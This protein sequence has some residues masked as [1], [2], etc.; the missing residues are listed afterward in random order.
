MLCLLLATAVQASV[1]INEET[2]PDEAFRSVIANM[3][4]GKDGILTDEEIAGI[5]ELNALWDSPNEVYSLK[6]IE[7]F[8]NLKTF[9][10]AYRH[11]RELD[12]SANKKLEY[13]RMDLLPLEKINL[14]GLTSLK[15]FICQRAVLPELDVSDC[16]ELEYL[17]C[18]ECSLKSFDL[19]NNIKLKKL[20]LL[21]TYLPTLD[22]S[23]NINLK[24]VELWDNQLTTLDL[25]NNI[26]LEKVDCSYNQLTN[27]ILPRTET[28]TDVKCFA[29]HLSG[30]SMDQV[31]AMLPTVAKGDFY[32]YIEI[33]D[34]DEEEPQTE[35]NVCTTIQVEAA[36]SKNWMVYG[37]Y[38]ITSGL[39]DEYAGSEPTSIRPAIQSSTTTER[40][41]LDGR[42]LATP[43]TKGLYIQNGKKY[44]VNK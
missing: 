21:A 22:L 8:T 24:E 23:N 17:C 5:E 43:P 40:Y 1:E 26:N 27:L 32:P 44:V 28:L 37:R 30:E 3:P 34:T 36:K 4:E 15:Y 14:K 35:F 33:A 42:R 9:D 25:S 41:S 38:H 12:F 29:N 13:I 7:F 18:Y 31:V 19:S 39:W 2:F 11:I 10:L 6:G 20:Q 16:T